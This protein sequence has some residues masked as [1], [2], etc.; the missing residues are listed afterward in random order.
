MRVLSKWELQDLEKLGHFSASVWILASN[1]RHMAFEVVG[2]CDQ[3]SSG[4]GPQP[5][6]IVEA[7]HKSL[8]SADLQQ[9]SLYRGG[10]SL[11]GR[12]KCCLLLYPASMRCLFCGLPLPGLGKQ[13]RLVAFS[14]YCSR[15]KNEDLGMFWEAA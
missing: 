10:S 14:L 8:L 7:P 12:R 13:G 15:L 6:L 5:L 9:C 4:A 2:V 3:L 1:S 11:F